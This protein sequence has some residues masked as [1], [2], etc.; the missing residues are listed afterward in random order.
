MADS[1]NVHF[2]SPYGMRVGGAGLVPGAGGGMDEEGQP[3]IMWG[4]GT[5]DGNLAPF[6]LV[7]KGS[8]YMEVNGT[9]DQAHMWQKVDEGGESGLDDWK[10]M[11][12]EDHKL[13]VAA[14]IDDAAAI[15]SAMIAANTIVAAD[16]STSAAI[17][18]ESLEVNAKV[19]TV[20]WG[21]VIDLAAS[22]A[23]HMVMHLVAAITITEIGLLFDTATEA[24]IATTI[25]VSES[26]SSDVVAAVAV[27]SSQ[28][29][30]AYQALTVADGDIPAGGDIRI[31]MAQGA[32]ETG[33]FQLIAKYHNV[34]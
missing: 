30:G 25:Q 24:S 7:N 2:L 34:S 3:A 8:L 22:S 5:P 6:N 15:T 16:I 1:L 4:Q 21:P 23:T 13:I 20:P 29:A 12:V 26:G 10:R 19:V 27:A 11:F 28:A 17:V 32:S 18:V 31:I 33:T 14:D 9:D